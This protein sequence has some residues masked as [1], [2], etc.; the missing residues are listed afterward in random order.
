MNDTIKNINYNDIIK[1]INNSYNIIKNN[2]IILENKSNDDFNL[3]LDY[4]KTLI[5]ENCENITITIP[6]I[7]QILIIN[8]KNIVIN[9]NKPV[10]GFFISKSKNIKLNE[11]ITNNT[12]ITYEF[13]NSYNIDVKN[14]NGNNNIF[15]IIYCDEI[16]INKRSIFI[17][18]F[19]SC[20]LIIKNN[21]TYF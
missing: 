6:K 16:F 19:D 11:I 18:F 12:D 9:Y 1:N 20:C 15:I 13:F 21:I 2:Q 5:I 3:L 17:N 14:Q 4:N 8:C 7:T 10:I